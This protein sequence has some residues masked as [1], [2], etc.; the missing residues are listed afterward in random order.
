MTESPLEKSIRDESARA[1]EAIRQKEENEIKKLDEIYAADMNS[2]WK[3]AEAETEARI[4]QELYRLSNRAILERR[5]FNLQ[6]IERFTEKMMDEVTKEIRNNAK[7]KQFL[8]KAVRDVTGKTTSEVEIHITPDDRTWE[9]DILA[10]VES[11]GKQHDIFIKEDPEVRWGGCII[12][13]NGGRI[14]NYTLERIYFRRSSLIRQKIMRILMEHANREKELI[15]A[16]AE[17]EGKESL[18]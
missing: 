6:S 12:F 9:K 3:Q 11:A 18:L 2:F 8:L 7:Y 10:A 4:N 17:P 15:P 1:I 16:A 13:D 5:K 14:F